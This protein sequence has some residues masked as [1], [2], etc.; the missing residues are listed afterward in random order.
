MNSN[1]TLP[2]NNLT[3]FNLANSMMLSP[4]FNPSIVLQTEE[5]QKA[6][7]VRG[8]RGKE[9]P[10]SFGSN[11]SEGIALHMLEGRS[12]A[13][14]RSLSLEHL[15]LLTRLMDREVEA[16]AGYVPIDDF[17]A[18]KRRRPTMGDYARVVRGEQSLDWLLHH[19]I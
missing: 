3:L 11:D 16:A 12:T 5:V 9:T 7:L 2:Q 15:S 19:D 13:W 8:L 4:W 1:Q 14:R 10:L 17:A 6:L 18:A